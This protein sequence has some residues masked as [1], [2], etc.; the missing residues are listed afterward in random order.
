MIVITIIG[1]LTAVSIP[2]YQDYVT[3]AKIT[4]GL[5]MADQ[6]EIAVA[7]KFQSLGYMPIGNNSSF[8]LPSSTSMSGKYVQSIAVTGGSGKITITYGNLGSGLA[9]GLFLTLTPA[10]S[11]AAAIAWACGY[12]SVTV[13]GNTIGGPAAGTTVPPRYLPLSCQG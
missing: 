5:S 10:T 3:R 13:N 6:A 7:E 1:I 4:E 8:D 2:L 11:P 9:T 12:D